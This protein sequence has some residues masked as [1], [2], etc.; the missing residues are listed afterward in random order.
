S[1]ASFSFRIG[2]RPS[3]STSS[4]RRSCPHCAEHRAITVP[5]TPFHMGPGLALKAVTGRCFSLMVFGVS[6]IAIDIEPLVRIVRGD[7]LLHGF[8]HT[9]LGATVIAIISVGI[10]RPICQFLLNS[11]TPD[12][13][14]PFLDWLRG[15][16]AISWP[17]AVTGAF[18]GTYSH[19][20]LDSI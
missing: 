3:R 12:P 11:W 8:T 19:V 2:T 13:H 1:I 5:F 18:V 15:Q 9:Y 7:A 6:Q 10:G 4:R 16:E 14:V 17:A 20:F